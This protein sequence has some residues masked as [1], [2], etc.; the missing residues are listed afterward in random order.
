M[1][2]KV[3]KLALSDVLMLE[4]RVL[5]ASEGFFFESF[6][7]RDFEAA[8]GL[9]VKFVQDNHSQS[10]HNVLRGLHYQIQHPQGKLVRVV[11]GSVFDVS[12]D[13]RRSSPNFGKWVGIELSAENKR[14]LWIPPGFAHGFVVTSDSAEFLYKTTDYWF[15]EYE[16]CLLWNDS[17]IGIKWPVDGVPKLAAKDAAARGLDKAEVFA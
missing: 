16:R 4:P 1:S 6:N 15:P 13:L 5:V 9:N 14:Q 11:S 17:A 7:Q 3:T 8:T 2:F 10:E 12:V